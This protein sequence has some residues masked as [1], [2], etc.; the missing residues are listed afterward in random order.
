MKEIE[1]S[2]GMVA[3]VDDEDFDRVNQFS[4]HH[5]AGRA[6]RNVV[7]TTNKI[8]SRK[9]QKM[10]RFI[11]ELSDPQIKVDHKN[12]NALDNRKENLRIATTSQNNANKEKYLGDCSSKYKG[13]YYSKDRN[14]WMAYIRIDGK[15]KN[16]GRFSLEED[17]ALAYNRAALEAFGEFAVLNQLDIFRFFEKD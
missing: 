6:F 5:D 11:L 3:L 10:H 2:N 16:L 13:V 1:L 4:W 17:A 7:K 9:T 15:M 8:V 14:K 12:R